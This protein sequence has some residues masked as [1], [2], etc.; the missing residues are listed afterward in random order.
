MRCLRDKIGRGTELSA[1]VCD[2]GDF[3]PQL[4]NL[5]RASCEEDAALSKVDLEDPRPE[6]L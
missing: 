3:V 2:R 4:L 1:V 6:I 5:L